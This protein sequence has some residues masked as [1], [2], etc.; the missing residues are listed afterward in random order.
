MRWLGVFVRVGMALA[1][2][3]ACRPATAAGPF[4]PKPIDALVEKALAAWHVPGVAVAI[5]QD[6]EVVYLKGH[7]VREIGGRDLVTADTVFPLASCSKAFTTTAMAML[8]DEGKM[9]WDDL[10]RK[11]L[12]TFRLSDPLADR[13]VV[14]RDLVCHRTGLRS[15]DLLWYRATWKPEEAVRRAGL[16]PLDKPFRSAFQYQ[17]TMFTAAGLC[18]S[19]ASGM[20]W[21][22]FVRRRILD[23]L[24][25]RATFFPSTD[26]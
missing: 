21:H 24:E 9:A 14:L 26:A 23:P 10:V 12:P 11:H 25:M 16:L 15:H 5:V 1:T 4:D 3:L 18:V 2:L 22:D 7:G 20:P 6:N 19:S 8:V 17:S 13:N